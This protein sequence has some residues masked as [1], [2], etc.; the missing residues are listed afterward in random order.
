MSKNAAAVKA[1]KDKLTHYSE[2]SKNYVIKPVAMETLG[3]WGPESLQ[4]VKEIGQRIADNTGDKRS[5]SFLL[6]AISMAVQRGN[7]ASI[8]GT[9]PNS[10]TLHELFYL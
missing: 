4:F 1:Q 5:T 10:K 7:V 8:R 2:L 9:V 3:A 6:Q